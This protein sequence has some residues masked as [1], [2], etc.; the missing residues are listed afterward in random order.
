MFELN[1]GRRFISEGG[2]GEG[3]V[4][5]MNYKIIIPSAVS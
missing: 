5:S 1:V 3:E 2:R 4:F